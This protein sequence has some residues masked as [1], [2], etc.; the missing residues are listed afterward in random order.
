MS[1]K[2]I[3]SLHLSKCSNT[4]IL[5]TLK[6]LLSKNRFYFFFLIFSCAK[7]LGCHAIGIN[8]SL[9]FFKCFALFKF[10]M[11]SQKSDKIFVTDKK[12][13]FTRE[14]VLD[15][16]AVLIRLKIKTICLK[17]KIFFK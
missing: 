1:R 16:K 8:S 13:V 4:F 5:Y 3:S 17:T 10:T 14:K 9:I 6:A 11:P 12:S 2:T 7:I 15:R